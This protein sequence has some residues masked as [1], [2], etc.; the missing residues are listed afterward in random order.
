MKITQMKFQKIAV[1]GAFIFAAIAVFYSLIFASQLYGFVNITSS[2]G[3]QGNILFKEVQPFNRALF[4]L[5]VVYLIASILL[6]VF[7][8][9]TRRIYY[10]S[11]YIVTGVV[12]VL[13]VALSVYALLNIFTYMSTFTSIDFVALNEYLTKRNLNEMTSFPW[14][15]ILGIIVFAGVIIFN[16]LMVVNAI[17]KSKVIKTERK[18]FAEIDAEIYAKWEAQERELDK[19]ANKYES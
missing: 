10:V 4:N 7:F 18:E 16:A 9:P 11:N 5:T 13:G 6:L 1:K 15:F 12:A 17:W 14:S 2:L 3:V 19:E 8:C